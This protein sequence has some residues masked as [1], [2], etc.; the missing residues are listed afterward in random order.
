MKSTLRH[1]IELALE[2][3][4]VR[5]N[6]DNHAELQ[7]VDQLVEAVKDLGKRV[8]QLEAEKGKN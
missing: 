6:S 1:Y 5:L 8:H 3:A 7:D 4:G 2:R